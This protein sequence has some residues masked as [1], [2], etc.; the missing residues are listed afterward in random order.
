MD[1]L[2]IGGLYL[3]LALASYGY[4]FHHPAHIGIKIH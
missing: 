3:L 4:L 1:C 2:L